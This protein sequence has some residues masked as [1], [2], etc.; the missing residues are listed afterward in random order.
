MA[1]PA[2]RRYGER[3][4]GLNQYVH[5]TLAPGDGTLTLDSY[6]ESEDDFALQVVILDAANRLVL[7]PSWRLR[8][9]WADVAT[10]ARARPS[11]HPQYAAAQ[12]W[13]LE[14]A[15]RGIENIRASGMAYTW[16]IE[17]DATG[18]VISPTFSTG[19]YENHAVLGA[20]LRVQSSGDGAGSS[21]VDDVAAAVLRRMAIS[22]HDAG[23]SA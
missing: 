10:D 7:P 1:T 3:D 5:M 4:D 11:K 8:L 18:Q 14:K 21:D 17:D 13:P 22:I 12:S 20:V 23:A 15:L 9:R 19:F 2:Y 6:R 16:W